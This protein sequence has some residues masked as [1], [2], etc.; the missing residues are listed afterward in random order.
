MMAWALW[1]RREATSPSRGPPT[2]APSGTV[3]MK[4][5]YY[6]AASIDG[7]IATEDDSLEW[8]FQ[9]GDPPDSSYPDFIA[10]VGAIA[11]GSTTYRWILRSAEQV[12]AQTASTW[13][14]TC[15][16]WVFS[17]RPQPIIPGANI[18]FASGD[19]R[20]V[21]PELRRAAGERNLW[22]AGGGELA[23]QF[24]DAGL[25]DELIVQVGSVIL[26]RGKPLLP[27]RLL[28]PTLRLTS[29]TRLGAEMVKL[30]YDVRT[31]TR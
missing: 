1:P 24:I 10:E 23:G 19:V 30:R 18:H 31:D 14:Y 7:F 4:T 28:S 15:P 21:F 25:L 13:A 2:H 9:L 11:M 3:G 29:V 27:R 6:T 5:Q 16:T 12:A 22:I 8:L 17:S 20:K 26:G